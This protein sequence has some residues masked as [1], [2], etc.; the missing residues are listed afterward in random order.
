MKRAVSR[1]RS[2]EMNCPGGD[3]ADLSALSCCSRFFPDFST[4]LWISSVQATWLPWRCPRSRI[5][6][7]VDNQTWSDDLDF[8]TP[9]GP[10]PCVE[11]GDLRALCS[12][13]VTRGKRL[14]R[15]AIVGRTGRGAAWLAR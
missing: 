15:G 10:K 6:R 9:F 12:D 2:A 14:R 5:S 3:A 11:R 7:G 8:K 1:S 13:F 4:G